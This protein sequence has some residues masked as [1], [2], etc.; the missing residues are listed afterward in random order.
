MWS[1]SITDFGFLP[2]INSTLWLMA[3]AL[4]PQAQIPVTFLSNFETYRLQVR[5]MGL[6]WASVAWK[7]YMKWPKSS[8]LQHKLGI[9]FIYGGFICVHVWVSVSVSNRLN[10]NI[11][12][13]PSPVSFLYVEN[14]VCLYC[15]L[16]DSSF[17]F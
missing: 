10:Q 11:G 9:M 16:S 2:S 5:Q 4:I 6:N 15:V 3:L 17:S 12:C 8:Q 1:F 14:S 7:W 13:F